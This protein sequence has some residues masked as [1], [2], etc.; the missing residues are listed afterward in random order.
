MLKIDKSFVDD[1]TTNANDAAIA[2]SVISLAH[3]L[4]LRVIAEG[5]ETREQMEFLA[6]RG[7]DEMQGYYF[8]R[9]VGA[10]A[11]TALLR[12]KRCVPDL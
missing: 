12:E 5:V 8:S 6:Q 11:F 9:P 4:N 2:L 7:C 10:D 3:N 1:V